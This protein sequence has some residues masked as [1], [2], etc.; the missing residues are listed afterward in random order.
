MGR[1]KTQTK[2]PVVVV[3]DNVNYCYIVSEAINR[4]R[5]FFCDRY[6]HSTRQ[7]KKNLKASDY[8]PRILLLDIDIPELSGLDSIVT[9]KKLIPDLLVVMLTSYEDESDILTAMQRGADGYIAKSTDHVDL[10]R[11]LE[12]LLEGGKTID[13][14]IAEKLIHAAL[15][16]TKRPDY[17]LTRREMETLR[18]FARGFQG[19]QI[20]QKL[21]ISLHTVDSHRK[22]LFEKLG[23][24]HLGEMVAKA[25]Q[26]RLID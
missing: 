25:H 15:G 13:P 11:S 24:H 4:S 26:E 7:A 9:F 16:K 6:Y 22:N 8:P 12:R 18:L 5:K 21:N 23:V 20:A 10:I 14:K 3:D 19:R 17:K 1:S 2:I